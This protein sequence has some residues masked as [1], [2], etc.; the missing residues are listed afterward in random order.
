MFKNTDNNHIR[1]RSFYF[2]AAFLITEFVLILPCAHAVFNQL[3]NL[4]DRYNHKGRSKQ[5]KQAAKRNLQENLYSANRNSYKGKTR[6][7]LLLRIFEPNG[8]LMFTFCL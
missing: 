1:I 3:L 5:E 6:N 2:V 8:L 7:Y 4:R